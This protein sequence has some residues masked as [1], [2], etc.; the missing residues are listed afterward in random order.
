[1]TNNEVKHHTI[2]EI[3]EVLCVVGNK[4][5][6]LKM[7]DDDSTTSGYCDLHDQITSMFNSLNKFKQIVNHASRIVPVMSVNSSDCI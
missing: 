7:L 1:M 5:R 2:N 4:V 6:I 3:S